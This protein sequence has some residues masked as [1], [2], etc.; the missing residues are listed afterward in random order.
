MW[1]QLIKTNDDVTTTL[2]RV[3]LGIVIFPHGA[4]KL[5]GWFGGGGVSGTI[6]FFSQA[7][8][9]PAILTLLV[10]VAEFFGALG[11]V[12]GFLGRV[13]A[14]GIAL[15]MAGAVFLVHVQNGFFMNWMGQQAGEGFEFHIL[16]IALCIAILVRGSGAVS[17]DRQ[18]AATAER[19]VA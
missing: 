15:V 3:A 6:D 10:I 13:A 16:V 12:V 1:Q 17:V 5:L 4:Q 2:L 14:G 11:L 18:L 9:L 8:G 19:L 7:F